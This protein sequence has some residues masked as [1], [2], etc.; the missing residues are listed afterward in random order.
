MR[1]TS[2][3]NSHIKNCVKLQQRKERDRQQMMVVEGYRAIL[4]AL[5]NGYPLSTVYYAPELFYGEQESQL[6][7]QAKR[8]G[9]TILEVAAEPFRKMAEAARPDG[10]LALAPQNRRRLSEFRPRP[11][12]LFLVAE[13]VEKPSNLGAII[14]SA[15]GAGADALIVCDPQVDIFNPDVVR[16]SVGTFFSLPLLISTTKEALQWCREQGITTLAA[17]PQ[18]ELLYTDVAMRGAVAIAVGNEQHGLSA[19]WL[20]GADLGVR[21]P[22]HGQINSLNVSVAAAILLYEAVRQR[23]G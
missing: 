23:N 16:A 15:D 5:Q 3:Q 18:A 10:L 19:E 4:C 20:C 12:A 6:L 17:T 7:R 1:I 2:L 21:L 22:M 8:K 11:Y 14:R 13:G 9:A